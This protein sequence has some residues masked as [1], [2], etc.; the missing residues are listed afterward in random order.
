MEKRRSRIRRVALCP[1]IG[2]LLRYQ[3]RTVRVV[4]EARGARAMIESLDNTGRAFVSTVKWANLRE[5][6]AQLF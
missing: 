4:A 6:D 5:L 1:R 2:A 3:T